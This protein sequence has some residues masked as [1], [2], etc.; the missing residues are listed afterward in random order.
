MSTPPDSPS[1]D[2]AL[3]VV[4]DATCLACGCLCDDIALEVSGGRIVEA[5]HACDRGRAWFLADRGPGDWP[6]A[7]IDGR[8]APREEALDRAAELLG[9]ARA[10]IVL[11]LTQTTVEAQAAAVALADRLGAVIDPSHAADAAPRL[12]AIARVGR[13]SATLGEVRDRA[14]LVVFWG[15]D[16]V[17]TH[18]RHWERY[19]VEPRGRFVPEGRAGRTIL[20]A[21]SEYTPTAARADRHLLVPADAQFEVLTALRALINKIELDPER[22]AA[23]TG[24]A[25]DDLL[26]WAQRLTRARFGAFFFDANLGRARGGA[27][28]VEAALMLVRDQNASTRLVAMTLGGPG[29][30]AGAESVLT[31]QAGYPVGVDYSAGYP[32]SL[33]G[34][35]AADRLARGEADVALIVADDPIT[36]L[37]QA[38]RDHLLRIPTV[39]LAPDATATGRRSSVALATATSGIHTAGTVVRTDGVML[40]LRPALTT[41]WP[42]DR[43]L[44][45]AIDERVRALQVGDRAPAPRPAE[46]P[47]S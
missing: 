40:P 20:A 35:T 14:D 29:N 23:A 25:W 13:V 41:E 43:E 10:P 21:A 24:V 1:H 27:A 26:E 19:S 16:P 18:P 2:P 33:A 36:A 5:R 39:L 46:V 28:T 12:S 15:V 31:W 45:R 22:V 17:T 4:E 42:T 44:L 32:R 8:P 7:T 9:R 37:P 11:G 30:P 6:A 38:A 3:A 47:T 34:E